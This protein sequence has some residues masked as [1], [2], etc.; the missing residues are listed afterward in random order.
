MPIR[1][2][3]FQLTDIPKFA[4]PGLTVLDPAMT[5]G[6]LTDRLGAGGFMSY[7][8]IWPRM[9]LLVRGLASDS[10]IEAQFAS[11]EDEW[12]NKSVQEAYRL[13]RKVFG[14]KGTWY[15][16]PPKPIDVLGALFRPCIKGIWFYDGQAY[17]VLINPRKQQ[18]LAT[19]HVRFV[20]RAVYEFHCI[21]DPNDPLPMIVDLSQPEIKA[22]RELR[23]FILS[24]TEIMSLDEFEQTLQRFFQALNL[25]GVALY[26][27]PDQ[28]IADLFRR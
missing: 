6:T 25:A 9:D 12:K 5:A 23:T 17:A 28:R 11:Y 24:E 13:L 7:G 22:D 26:P 19:E 16:Y 1:R 10:F 2:K 18:R 4:S 27:A 8:Q 15:P 21:A 14:G 3:L 20:G